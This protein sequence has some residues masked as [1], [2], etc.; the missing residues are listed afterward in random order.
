LGLHS[1]FEPFSGIKL[2][3]DVIDAAPT[4]FEK[5]TRIAMIATLFS[6]SLTAA[7]N[8]DANTN[9]AVGTAVAAHINHM[10]SLLVRGGSQITNSSAVSRDFLVPLSSFNHFEIIS[11]PIKS[12]VVPKF[13]SSYQKQYQENCKIAI[14]NM[15]LER[16]YRYI[17]NQR[18]FHEF[19]PRYYM[20]PMTYSKHLAIVLLNKIV[21][22]CWIFFS[23]ATITFV[24][25][26]F[27][28]VFKCAEKKRNQKTE[29]II[30]MNSLIDYKQ[31][32][33][34]ETK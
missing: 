31:Y 32:K 25:F 15:F 6:T 13:L 17:T 20:I 10:R 11:N 33:I 19:N 12:S 1:W 9:T 18:L 27:L 24:I 8:S 22:C 4:V 34:N 29:I 5:R 14:E 2:A 23:I 21:L 28:Y 3:L 7:I 30:D 16:R 26:S